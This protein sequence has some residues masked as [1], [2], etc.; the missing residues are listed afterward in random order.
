VHDKTVDKDEKYWQDIFN[1][2]NFDYL[3]VEYLNSLLVKFKDGRNWEIDLRSK[4]QERKSNDKI[5]QDFFQQY[6]K[7][8]VHI[9]FRVD[10]KKVK[11][12][13]SKRTKR[14]LKFNK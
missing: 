3:P 12:D 14:F 9:D 10:L 6:N 2:V 8:I 5:L 7:E 4:E 1:T 13:V 11:N